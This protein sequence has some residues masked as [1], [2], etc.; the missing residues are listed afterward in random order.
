MKWLIFA[1]SV[2][3]PLGCS[4]A[5]IP[6]PYSERELKLQCERHGGRWH[7]GQ[8]LFSTFCEYDSRT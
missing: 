8:L 4:Q 2:M 7:E 3:A 6:P 1:L 5:T